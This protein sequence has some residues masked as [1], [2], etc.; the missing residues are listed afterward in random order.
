MKTSYLVSLAL[1]L[2][3]GA[4]E[5]LA[6]TDSLILKNGNVIVGE[7]KSLN[8]GVLTIETGYSKKDFTIEWSGVKEIFSKSL[9]LIT[10][11]DGRRFNGTVNTTGEDK[12][13]TI[14]ENGKE[15]ATSVDEVVFLKGLKA[16]FWSRM[17]AHVDLGISF[18]KA[19]NLQQIIMNSALSY[20]ANKW[21]GDVYYDMTKS[22]QDSISTTK[23]IDGGLGAKY[24]LQHDWFL[25]ASLSFLSNTE[26]ALDLRTTGKLGGGKFLKHTNKTYWNVAGGLSFNNESFTNET[27]SR[28]SLEA[29]IG[30]ELNLF[31]IGDLN[32]LT[33]VWVYPSLT[34]SGRWRTD[35]QFDAKYDL[36]R[37][38]YIKANL[39]LNYDSKPAK[40]GAE[41]DY[42]LGFTF[43]WE[44]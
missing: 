40:V 8:N 42:V 17:S 13:L 22:S 19:N 1:L 29:F 3:M 12:K 26:Q 38:F 44:L 33:S 18:S 35:F 16:D 23:R 11:T 37:D 21:Q 7:I 10:L 27:E 25:S 36:P 15:T 4:K 5:L 34:E 6:Q 41:T 9:F 43:G 28:S 32:L 20:L 31:D 30:S 24:F 14:V 2:S 39:T